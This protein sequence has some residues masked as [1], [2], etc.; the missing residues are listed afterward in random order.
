MH[1]THQ[2]AV[3]VADQAAA[4]VAVFVDLTPADVLRGAAGYLRRHGF[5]QGDMF[6]TAVS[7]TPP[8]CAQGA[9]KMAICGSAYTNWTMAQSALFDLTMAVLAG[10]V[11]L[12][13][14]WDADPFTD[15]DPAGPAD[16]VADWNDATER[17]VEQ[18]ITAMTTAADDWDHIT[19][20]TAQLA[21]YLPPDNDGEAEA[22]PTQSGTR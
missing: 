21:A 7:L 16:W 2:P 12:P 3:E 18:V 4:N 14:D 17:T 5:H 20:V 13:Y 9:V 19:L 1:P 10:R 15:K 11:G 6:A 22:D 8:A